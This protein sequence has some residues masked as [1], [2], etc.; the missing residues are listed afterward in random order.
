MASFIARNLAGPYLKEYFQPGFK[1]PS[2]NTFSGTVTIENMKFKPKALDFLNLP[3]GIKIGYVGKVVVTINYSALMS[4]TPGKSPVLVAVSDVLIVVGPKAQTEID[5][6]KYVEEMIAAKL[7][8]LDT[9]Q[10]AAFPDNKEAQEAYGMVDKIQDNICVDVKNFH[11][12]FETP[13]YAF[14]ITLKNLSIHTTD[15]KWNRITPPKEPKCIYRK[16]EMSE[17]SMYLNTVDE[18]GKKHQMADHKMLKDIW[19][20]TSQQKF[21]W[22]HLI[23]PITAEL[24]VAME[25]YDEEKL[26]ATDVAKTRAEFIFEPL[27]FTLSR[28]QYY[29]ML[30]LLEDVSQEEKVPTKL[31]EYNEKATNEKRDEYISLYKTL[32]EDTS[33]NR[34]Y[35]MIDK[36][37]E[38]LLKSYERNWSFQDVVKFR[39]AAYEV[40]KLELEIE[41]PQLTTTTRSGN[42]GITANFTSMFVSGPKE[43]LALSLDK[44]KGVLDRKSEAEKKAKELLDK[45]DRL[46]K[47]YVHTHAGIQFKRLFFTL[48]DE[49]SKII[50]FE[51]KDLNLGYK[52]RPKSMLAT[53]VIAE[54]QC[55]DHVTRATKHPYFMKGSN[56]EQNLVD[57]LYETN[58]PVNPNKIDS[59]AKVR[60]DSIDIVVVMAVLNEISHFFTPPTPVDLSQLQQQAMDS[61]QEIRKDAGQRLKEAIANRRR[62][63]IDIQIKAPTLIIPEEPT[64]EKCP[65]LILDLGTLV[66]KS[67]LATH[68]AKEM[69]LES[70]IKTANQQTVLTERYRISLYDSFTLEL[71]NLNVFLTS[72]PRWKIG[73]RDS[74]RLSIISPLSM[75]LALD[76]AISTALLPLPSIC[77]KGNITKLQIIISPRRVRQL[78]KISDALSA[79]SAGSAPASKPVEGKAEISLQDK[80]SEGKGKE[81]ESKRKTLEE[82]EKIE[83]KIQ[84][85]IEASRNYQNTKYD[86]SL[87]VDSVNLEIFND[88]DSKNVGI[89]AMRVGT[90]ALRF[91]QREYDMKASLQVKSIS[92]EDHLQTHGEAF[93]YM[94]STNKDSAALR[95]LIQ[96]L[97]KATSVEAKAGEE[98]NRGSAENFFSLEVEMIQP[99]AKDIYDN[100]KSQLK[101]H[102][103]TLVLATNRESISKIAY[104][105]SYQLMPPSPPPDEEDDIEEL[106]PLPP[107]VDTEAQN[108]EDGKQTNANAYLNQAISTYQSEHEKTKDES[109]NDAKEV[110]LTKVETSFESLQVVLCTD[111]KVLSRAMIDNFSA[112]FTDSDEHKRAQLS[113]DGI[114]IRDLTGE[115]PLYPHMVACQRGRKLVDINLHMRNKDLYRASDVTNMQSSYL[116]PNQMPKVTLTGAISGVTVTFLNRFVQEMAAYPNTILAEMASHEPPPP[117]ATRIRRR[118]APEAEEFPLSMGPAEA[119]EQP[120]RRTTKLHHRSQRTL[121]RGDGKHPTRLPPIVTEGD[122]KD[123]KARD[124]IKKWKKDKG[125]V[126]R[127]VSITKDEKMPIFDFYKVDLQLRKIEV[128]VPKGSKSTDYM[129]MTLEHIQITNCLCTEMHFPRSLSTQGDHM[130]FGLVQAPPTPNISHQLQSPTSY[131]RMLTLDSAGTSAGASSLGSDEFQDCRDLK[132]NVFT[133]W[134]IVLN[135]LHAVTAFESKLHKISRNKPLPLFEIKEPAADYKNFTPIAAHV[136][137]IQ[138][139]PQLKLD[140]IVNPD[141]L[142]LMEVATISMIASRIQLEFLMSLSSNN[143]AEEPVIV[144]S[145][146]PSRASERPPMSREPSSSGD[147]EELAMVEFER[148][149]EEKHVEE[150]EAAARPSTRKVTI[151][152]NHLVMKLVE[153]PTADRSR[154]LGLAWNIHMALNQKIDGSLNMTG[155]LKNVTMFNT[156]IDKKQSIGEQLKI[157]KSG[158]YI[159][160]PFN[161]SLE[162]NQGQ[163]DILPEDS[164]MNVKVDGGLVNLRLTYQDYK[165]VMD[166]VGFLSSSEEESEELKEEK[167]NNSADKKTLTPVVPNVVIPIKSSRTVQGGYLLD[168]KSIKESCVGT[169]KAMDE[170]QSY[171]EQSVNAVFQGIS[172][173][174]INNVTGTDVPFASFEMLNLTA[175]VNGFAHQQRVVATMG[176]QASYYNSE[177]EDWEPMIEPWNVQ[178][179][180]WSVAGHGKTAQV[181]TSKPLYINLTRAMVDALTSTMTLVNKVEADSQGEA[182]GKMQKFSLHMLENL[183]H[184]TLSYTIDTNGSALEIEEKLKIKVSSGKDSKVMELVPGSEAP[185]SFKKHQKVCPVNIAL[186]GWEPLP[187]ID[188]DKVQTRTHRLKA[189]D[190]KESTG[191]TVVMETRILGGIKILSLHSTV[192]VT[193][194]TVATLN[195]HNVVV[196]PGDTMWIPLHLESKGIQVRPEIIPGIQKRCKGK[197]QSIDPTVFSLSNELNIQD[198]LKEIDANSEKRRK[199]RHKEEVP[200]TN[201]VDEANPTTLTCTSPRGRHFHLAAYASRKNNSPVV[202]ITLRAP[203]VIENVLACE[204]CVT[205]STDKDDGKKESISLESKV[206]LETP[207]IPKREGERPSASQEVIEMT[208]E[209]AAKL[210]VFSFRATEVCYMRLKVKG[211]DEEWS[212]PVP[213]TGK[214][215]ADE[216]STDSNGLQFLGIP[217]QDGKKVQSFVVHCEVSTNDTLA[218]SG[219]VPTHSNRIAMFVPYWVFDATGLGLQ[220]SCNKSTLIARSY[221]NTK[222]NIPSAF[223][224]WSRNENEPNTMAAHSMNEAFEAKGEMMSF[225]SPMSSE[226]NRVSIRSMTPSSSSW[227]QYFS[228]DSAETQLIS[229]ATNSSANVFWSHG[230]FDV[231]VVSSQCVGRFSRT[232]VVNFCSR[233]VLVNN[234]KSKVEFRQRADSKSIVVD[235][236]GQAPF[237]FL[238]GSLKQYL[239]MRILSSKDSTK[240]STGEIVE[241]NWTGSFRISEPCDFGLLAR[242][243]N[244]PSSFLLRVEVRATDGTLF[245]VI[246]QEHSECPPFKIVNNCACDKLRFCQ[247]LVH[248]WTEVP[249]LSMC[250]YSWDQ[251]LG[252]GGEF[253]LSVEVAGDSRGARVYELDEYGSLDRIPLTSN[254]LLYVYLI[255]E[256][257]TKVLVVSDLPNPDVHV[258]PRSTASEQKKQLQQIR[259]L[260]SVQPIAV[261]KRRQNVLQEELQ[262]LEDMKREMLGRLDM[263]KVRKQTL[264]VTIIEASSLS[265]VKWHG[266]SDVYANVIFNGIARS[267][268]VLKRNLNPWF[269]HSFDFDATPYEENV[270]LGDQGHPLSCPLRISLFSSNPLA[271]DDFLGGTIINLMSLRDA[272]RAGQQSAMD[273]KRIEGKESKERKIRKEVKIMDEKLGD[274]DYDKKSYSDETSERTVELQ[275]WLRLGIS[276]H[277]PSPHSKVQVKLQWFPSLT[278]KEKADLMDIG[279]RIKEKKRCR[280]R[281]MRRLRKEMTAAGADNTMNLRQISHAAAPRKQIMFTLRVVEAK[282]NLLRDRDPTEA[283]KRRDIKHDTTFIDEP[284]PLSRV[285]CVVSHKDHKRMCILHDPD[286]RVPSLKTQGFNETFEFYINEDE[287]KEESIRIDVYAQLLSIQKDPPK[288]MI[289]LSRVDKKMRKHHTNS[290]IHIGN[291]K[292]DLSRAPSVKRETFEER[293]TQFRSQGMESQLDISNEGT[294]ENEEKLGGAMVSWEKLSIPSSEKEVLNNAI[295][296]K[297]FFGGQIKISF[298]Q[299][300]APPPEERA[301]TRAIV[302]LDEFGVSMIDNTPEEIFFFQVKGLVAAYEDGPTQSTMEFSVFH[303]QLDNC[304]SFAQF[305]IVLAPEPVPPSQRKPFLQISMHQ[306]KTQEGVPV[307]IYQYTSFLMQR[308]KLSVEERVLNRLMSYANE[309]AENKGLL[310][311]DEDKDDGSD[312]VTSLLTAIYPIPESSAGKMFFSLLQLHPIA[313]D[314]SLELSSEERN[315]QTKGD[316]SLGF[317]PVKMIRNAAGTAI[318]IDEAPLRL[319]A[320]TIED[321]YGNTSTLLTPIIK[322]YRNQFIREA[323]KILG[324]LEILGNPVQL[325]G[326]LGEGVID[327]FYEPA[328][329]LVSSPQDF[330][331][332]LARGTSS[333]LKHTVT[334]IFGAASKVTGKLAEGIAVLGMDE[335]FQRRARLEARKPPKH[336]GEG[337]VQGG[338]SIAMGI[339]RGITGVVTDPY[340]G[341]RSQGWKGFMKGCGTG[342]IGIGLKPTAG[343]IAAASKILQGVGNTATCCDESYENTR[344]RNPRFIQ[345]DRKIRPYDHLHASMAYVLKRIE[346][347]N[348]TVSDEEKKGER[349]HSVVSLECGRLVMS[350][351]RLLLLPRERKRRD[352]RLES[353]PKFIVLWK[354]VVG[355]GTHSNNII[356]KRGVG[357]N[358]LQFKVGKTK[359]SA[360]KLVQVLADVRE[361]MLKK[362]PKPPSIF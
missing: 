252:V 70:L 148:K 257:P 182:K 233:Y 287:S 179:D 219:Y 97:K 280:R 85:E 13:T 72:N 316:T 218:E 283:L 86:I 239:Q 312:I 337:L 201:A 134:D 9:W 277:V 242:G 335:E 120:Y 285:I 104:F 83:K 79:A 359:E 258:D 158:H 310:G 80:L 346:I 341:Y 315:T 307:S 197:V 7:T 327:F 55:T 61:L 24:R 273:T 68:L 255:A 350:N 149:S 139:I 290:Y 155:K 244:Y 175:T 333:L 151:V 168:A 220:I 112:S 78:L 94:I 121:R 84:K 272:I 249:P 30:K 26:A 306:S 87:Q 319:N 162:V 63:A 161:L 81:E 313:I 271:P 198:I 226:G 22:S 45:M 88:L 186:K 200:D 334:G 147:E 325:V 91:R 284:A 292:V 356:I 58:P 216:S 231:G 177:V 64:D 193:N 47:T 328:M 67:R 339:Y 144:K 207:L 35:A 137:A 140:P 60:V 136:V 240:T 173:T 291:C 268:P 208:M 40:A 254:R 146:E 82:K 286:P 308:V 20:P 132:P 311:L 355:F 266:K 89:I 90:I 267:T 324:S 338:R 281:L 101:L 351:I 154:T 10:K 57:I 12:R 1:G 62:S 250:T 174:L 74:T 303:T 103:G 31:P 5:P 6:K 49:N 34:Q 232:R 8:S 111:G 259:L 352:S 141:L 178:A 269:E 102:V 46:P 23:P 4:S 353:K 59:L 212:K 243:K 349:F 236:G 41:S 188:V 92:L 344:A 52:A 2:V 228:L 194:A 129:A 27:G 299:R 113:L 14:G 288:N 76:N 108:E 37:G 300:P 238:N 270:K 142:V 314:I 109:G 125:I 361:K 29:N 241:W 32:F 192:C 342:V 181:K 362:S 358:P 357:R 191:P 73:S 51:I 96:N 227:S 317:N 289:S 69:Q 3:V 223:A 166:S 160:D 213:I 247:H 65:K 16:L 145:K 214:E 331:R 95:Q 75:P 106:N 329:G 189:K 211:Y 276:R 202:E 153:D 33:N 157:L 110:F 251:P 118:S 304:L 264:R 21:M 345:P 196:K 128:V 43:A 117:S 323:Y 183:T 229:C 123:K 336:I 11:M 25:K 98:D 318:D 209:R 28:K 222:H 282:L 354:D 150:L 114:W 262:L 44:Y 293:A 38:E 203:I 116:T 170:V 143:L 296:D 167:N 199:K 127:K 330:G 39:L 130:S 253:S 135:K 234:L 152:F 54:L 230:I 274:I 260:E 265:G 119:P 261:L 205:L 263:R 321:A 332:G 172:I 169:D 190:E 322:H 248:K 343:T 176:M 279:K 159:M 100:V 217:I 66:L 133:K 225:Y 50:E 99:E 256:G 275:R 245:V 53:V 187:A 295:L 138:T 297:G 294:P 340:H 19:L 309:F 185:L 320:L 122:E 347:K 93:K 204:A 221:E 224:K 278:S 235:A 131:S 206:T 56:P 165:L 17:L 195:C 305:P 124:L 164:A 237:H 126:D 71:Q 180:I 15:E 302:S 301:K 326:N 107:L 42:T 184:T 360:D 48:K 36:K 210:E 215:L 156:V 298:E 105:F 171:G 246:D 115:A 18:I 348:F 77:V 163:S